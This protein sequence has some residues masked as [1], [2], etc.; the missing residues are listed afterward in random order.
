MKVSKAALI[1]VVAAVVGGAV[2]SQP[3]HAV[4]INGTISFTGGSGSIVANSPLPGQ[5]TVD[6][7][8]GDLFNVNSGLGDYSGAVG[9]SSNFTDITYTG[10]G[11]AV[12]LVSS[13]SPEWSFT[14]GATTYTY[15]LLALTNVTF[16]PG[17][18]NSLT[19]NGTGV[20]TITGF[21]PTLASFSLQGTGSNFSFQIFQASDTAVGERVPDGGSAMA[22]LGLALA[23]V[24]GLRRKLRLS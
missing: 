13:N 6:F 8:L 17:P 11:P 16:T 18:T 14:L 22:L 12:V 20:A 5:T 21:D 15:N 19:I 7:L 4:A 2:L 10:T 24:E 9:G 23:G 3:A 1:A